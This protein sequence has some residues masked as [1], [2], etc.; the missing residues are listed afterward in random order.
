MVTGVGLDAAASC[1]A[2]RVGI[3]GF[4]DTPFMFAGEWLV[5]SPV[6]FEEPYSGRDKLVRMV[7]PAIAE[8]LAGVPEAPA[9]QIPLILCL[10]ETDRPGRFDGLDESVLRDVEE[11]LSTSFHRSSSVIAEGRLGGARA[12]DRGRQLVA[13]GRPYCVVAGVDTLLVS[14]TLTASNRERRLK[15]A[16]NS[17]GFIPGEAAGALLLGPAGGTRNEMRCLGIGYGFEPSVGTDRP[18]RADGLVTALKAA[19]ADSGATYAD[20]D[21]RVTDVSGGQDGFKEATLAITRT[22]RERKAGFEIWHPADCIGEVG[23]AVV[24]CMLGVALAAATKRY[25]PGPGVLAHVGS[26][27]GDRAAMILRFADGASTGSLPGRRA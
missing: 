18:L 12:I 7:V 6:P 1:A 15:T 19:L 17:D 25:A 4:V 11:R 2:M 8:C 13:E 23:A 10:A 21:Y 16:D 9:G 20:V 22:L 26:D 27:R 5:G 14:Q 24:P 3:T